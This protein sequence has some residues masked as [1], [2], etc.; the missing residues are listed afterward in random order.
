MEMRTLQLLFFSYHRR[1]KAAAACVPT[2]LRV[3]FA[4]LLY[5]RKRTL[6]VQTERPPCGCTGGSTPILT[7]RNLHG[8]TY[9]FTCPH[10][11]LPRACA[12]L[13]IEGDGIDHPKKSKKKDEKKEKL[14]HIES[15]SVRR[16]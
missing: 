11:F 13:A 1:T 2:Y 16:V 15:L 7:D 4:R 12:I 8:A 5:R 14:A 9:F 10:N 3:I 6:V